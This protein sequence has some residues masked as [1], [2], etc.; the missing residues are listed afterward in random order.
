MPDGK[1]SSKAVGPCQINLFGVSPRA[2]CPEWNG[3]GAASPAVPKAGLP[4]LREAH[5]AELVVDWTKSSRTLCSICLAIFQKLVE[6]ASMDVKEGRPRSRTSL[7]IMASLA[8]RRDSRHTGEK[9]YCHDGELD[10]ARA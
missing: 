2:A 5:V 1:I 9:Q 4:K 8:C 10:A 3:I 7:T 6:S